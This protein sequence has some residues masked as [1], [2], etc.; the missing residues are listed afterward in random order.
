MTQARSVPDAGG[1]LEHA[2]DLAA[3]VVIA[4]YRLAKLAQLH[5]LGNQA[6]LN[7]LEQTHKT[8]EEYCLK[9]GEN[10]NVLFA[11]RAVFV[12]GQLLKGSRAT[13]ES[14]AELGEILAWCGGADLTITRDVTVE[15]LR[16]F[17]EAISASM[18]S[19]KGT[20]RLAVES[21]RLRP[22]AA[23]ARL[24]GLEVERVAS[25]QRVVRV[26]SSAIVIMRRLLEDVER[27]RYVL[28]RRVKRVAQSIVDLSEGTTASFLGVTE[29]RNAAA[30]DGGRA[31]NGAILAVLVARQLTKDRAVLAEVAM[32]ALVLDVGRPRAVAHLQRATGSTARAK[33][34]ED[35]ED[36]LPGGTAAVL[37]DR[38]STRLNSSHRL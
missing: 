35:E 2:R 10:V 18:R 32:S 13:Y 21:V 34:G 33:L 5:D 16:A 28:P 9:S 17:A 7:Q 37:I 26:Y 1:R 4:I 20:F 11:R 36:R 15:E 12:A 22:V 14:A 3:G 24:R 8:I 31:V 19:G 30:D 29:M 6:F 38:K 23:A 25:E 27:G